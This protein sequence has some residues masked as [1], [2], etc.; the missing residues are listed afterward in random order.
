[1]DSVRA[2]LERVSAVITARKAS[3]TSVSAQPEADSK[4]RDNSLPVLLDQILGAGEAI[5]N[6]RSIGDDL[7]LGTISLNISW[8]ANDDRKHLPAL[9][10]SSTRPGIAE[11]EWRSCS[12]QTAGEAP[13]VSAISGERVSARET[14]WDNGSSS[15]CGR[16]RSRRRPSDGTF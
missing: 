12:R 6:F 4:N 16:R 1:M 10:R 15:D 13:P 14:H 7:S 9:D 2:V 3:M 5:T 8:I 11:K